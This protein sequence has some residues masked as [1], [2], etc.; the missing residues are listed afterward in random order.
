MESIRLLLVEDDRPTRLRLAAALSADPAFVID[1]AGTLAEARAAI[2]AEM[3]N[4]LITDL[5]LPDGHGADLIRE[6][7]AHY[8]A[9]ETLVVSVL[10]DEANVVAAITAGASGYILKDALPEDIASSVHD[11]LR[12]HSPVSGA[13]ARYILRQVQ[14]DDPMPKSDAPRLTKRE[15]DILWGIAKGFTYAEIADQLG[16]SRKTV[17]NYI[18]NVYR[19]LEVRSRSEAVFEAVQQGLIRL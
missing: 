16:I 4:I 5:H 13:I 10:C 11:V 7:R 8:P 3:P 2:A 14:A 18:K 19:K 15:I 9:M 1:E 12:G 17:P 6:V